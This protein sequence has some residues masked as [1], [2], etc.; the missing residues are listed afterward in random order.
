[1]KELLVS[2][3]ANRGYRHGEIPWFGLIYS[4]STKGLDPQEQNS[5]FAKFLKIWISFGW[6]GLP[7]NRSE[8]FKNHAE[9]G[10]RK[11]PHCKLTIGILTPILLEGELTGKWIRLSMAFPS[12]KRVVQ[13]YLFLQ[14]FPVQFSR[15]RHNQN[16]SLQYLMPL[17]G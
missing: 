9:V 7:L 16:P 13:D 6:L 10:L 5:Y 4:G 17:L 3:F 12:P 8:L 15:L 14:Q 2:P 11:Y 1:M